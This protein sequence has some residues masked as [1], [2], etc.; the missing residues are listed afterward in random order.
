MPPTMRGYDGTL[1]EVQSV[2]DKS[3][4]HSNRFATDVHAR[5]DNGT[6]SAITSL[7]EQG[8]DVTTVKEFIYSDGE[9]VGRSLGNL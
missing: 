2:I 1:R 5:H 9:K 8:E 7:E 3:V 6:T 4:G